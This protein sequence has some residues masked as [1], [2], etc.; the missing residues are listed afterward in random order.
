MYEYGYVV[1]RVP[2]EPLI[3]T[4]LTLASLTQLVPDTES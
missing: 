1:F 4:Y 3:G 2:Q